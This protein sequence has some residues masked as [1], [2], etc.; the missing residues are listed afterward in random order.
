MKGAALPATLFALA[1]TSAM[2]VGGVFV[3]RRHLAS[4]LEGDA[5]FALRPSAELAAVRVIAAWDSV[6]RANQPIGQSETLSE[7]PSATVSIVR[8]GELEYFI[9]VTARTA[10]RPVLYHRLGL[11]VV[12]EGGKARLPFPR[13][14][15]LLPLG[16]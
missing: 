10:T 13:A 7:T 9:V 1:I 4:S 11:S 5:G 2:A 12:M 3:V 14:W 6:A 15:T 8:T 16:G